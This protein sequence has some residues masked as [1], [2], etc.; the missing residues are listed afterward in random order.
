MDA[1]LRRRQMFEAE[2]PVFYEK[3]IF[4]GTAY[5]DTDILF[6]TDGSI[7]MMLGNESLKAAQR[8]FSLPTTNSGYIALSYGNNTDSTKRSLT[9]YYG[10]STAA[11]TNYNINFTNTT[12]AFFLT[13]KR[14][15]WVSNTQTI[16]KGSGVP[17]GPLTLGYSAS[18]TGQP[19]TG[20]M[21]VV[22]IYGSDAQDAT[23]SGDLWNNYTPVYTL[24]PCTYRGE[25]GLWCEETKKFY[26]NSAGSGSLTVS[27]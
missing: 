13:P 26:G 5:I 18:H 21:Q 14:F 2:V 17:S 6:P 10:G 7:R 24:R 1:L 22:K 20:I 27:N 15:G 25:A 16:T 8:L 3:I 11:Y 9:V 4:D 23:S 19:Y 12:F